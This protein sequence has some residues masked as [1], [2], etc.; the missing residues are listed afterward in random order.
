MPCGLNTMIEPASFTLKDFRFDKIK[1]DFSV[2]KGGELKL[3][4]KP[5]GIFHFSS[6]TFEL[7]FQFIASVPSPEESDQD[8]LDVNCISWFEFKNIDS[9]EDIPDYFFANS[10][11]IVFPYVRAFISN[12]TLQSNIK[13]LVLP[14]MNLSGLQ[15]ELKSNVSIER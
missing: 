3:H 4:I 14:T 10:V 2:L 9:Y 11:A 1:M 6:K 15:D 12:I 7:R 13:P 8:V 5:S